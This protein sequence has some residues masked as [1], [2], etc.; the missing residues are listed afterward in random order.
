MLS[1]SLTINK[2]DLTII[3]HARK[4]LPYNHETPWQ[5]KNAILFDVTV[6]AYDGAEVCELVDLFLF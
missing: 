5:K 4:Y 6:G 1:P 2:E 3:Q